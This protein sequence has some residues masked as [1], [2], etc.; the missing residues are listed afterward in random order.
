[1]SQVAAS[2]IVRPFRSLSPEAEHFSEGL[3]RAG[4]GEMPV[5]DATNRVA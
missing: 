1:M 2:I 4:L 5:Q 3:R